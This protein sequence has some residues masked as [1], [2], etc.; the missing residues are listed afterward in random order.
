[1]APAATNSRREIDD[2][3]IANSLLGITGSTGCG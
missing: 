1:V 3:F 2:G